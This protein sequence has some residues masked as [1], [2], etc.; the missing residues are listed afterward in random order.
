MSVQAKFYVGEV[1]HY[2]NTPTAAK[3]RMGAVCRGKENR[4]WAQAT[5]SGTIEL[6]IL[7]DAATAYF[8][9]GQEYL[10]VF[11][12]VAKPA[13]G[14]GHAPIP[15]KEATDAQGKPIGNIMCE[16][17]GG[18][19]LPG[20]DGPDWSAHAEHFGGPTEPAS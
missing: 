10:V 17:C 18:Y 3:V 15:V 9:Q 20:P 1:Q 13:A 11:T 8:E 4:Q 16:F 7:N 19:A 5:P 12:K 6:S 2:P 14:D